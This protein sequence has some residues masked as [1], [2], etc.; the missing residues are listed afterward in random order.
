VNT[1]EW[2]DKPSLSR[3]HFGLSIRQLYTCY[4]YRTMWAHNS[5]MHVS[6]GMNYVS[7][8]SS[9]HANNMGKNSIQLHTKYGSNVLHKLVSALPTDRVNLIKSLSTFLQVITPAMTVDKHTSMAGHLEAIPGQVCSR[10]DDC[11]PG[12]SETQAIDGVMNSWEVMYQT[13]RQLTLH[14]DFNCQ[15]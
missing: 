10:G 7:C 1:R 13:T 6:V 8:T 11:L 5:V 3:R 9:L 15:C 14:L 12:Q 4:C 2:P